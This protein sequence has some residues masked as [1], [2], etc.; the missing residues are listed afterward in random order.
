[1]FGGHNALQMHVK[2]VHQKTKLK[3]DIACNDCNK[4][5]LRKQDLKVHT[6][7]HKLETAMNNNKRQNVK[8]QQE[9]ISDGLL[10]S[11]CQTQFKNQHFLNEH[12]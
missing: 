2:R 4:L 9:N 8:M 7:T 3:E 5:F 10:C 6:K 1:M 11:I 12:I